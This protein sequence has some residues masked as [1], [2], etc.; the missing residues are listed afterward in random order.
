MCNG[1]RCGMIALGEV[2]V[3]NQTRQPNTLSPVGS[4]ATNTDSESA[5]S[6]PPE[7][8]YVTSVFVN[9][10]RNDNDELMMLF[11]CVTQT[12]TSSRLVKVKVTP[13]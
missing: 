1:L 9:S 6:R 11:K 2:C 13:S 8:D 5:C 12:S 10:D 4:S 7:V 3:I